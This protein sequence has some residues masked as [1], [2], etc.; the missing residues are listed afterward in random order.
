VTIKTYPDNK[1]KIEFINNK[2]I[3]YTLNEI[4]HTPIVYIFN[5]YNSQK[6]IVII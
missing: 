5:S 1:K 2:S 3:Q 4:F 6:Y